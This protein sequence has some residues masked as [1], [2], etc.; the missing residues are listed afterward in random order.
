MGD[1]TCDF[2]FDREA[3]SECFDTLT[4]EL[5]TAILS[6]RNVAGTEWECPHPS[7]DGTY[8][9]FHRDSENTSGDEAQAVAEAL[10]TVESPPPE[11]PNRTQFLGATFDT[12]EFSNVDL[13]VPEE[14][15]LDFLGATFE[16]PVSF[17]DQHLRDPSF[18]GATFQDTVSFKRT[19]L[20]DGCW[21][22]E[23]KFDGVTSFTEASVTGRLRF[24]GAEFT[25]FV[26][27]ERAEIDGP[28]EL[29]NVVCEDAVSMRGANI[30]DTMTIDGGTYHHHVILSEITA[31]DE[32]EIADPTIGG[33]IDI[34]EAEL[35]ERATLD[36]VKILIDDQEAASEAGLNDVDEPDNDGV[37]LATSDCVCE[38]QLYLRDCTIHGSFVGTTMDAPTLAVFGTTVHGELNLTQSTFHRTLGFKDTRISGQ[39]NFFSME[40][41]HGCELVDVTVDGLLEAFNADLEGVVFEDVDF[42][43][44]RFERADLSGGNLAG[45]DLRAVDFTGA[46]MNRAV[47]HDAD[48][49]GA[50]LRG[51]ALGDIRITDNT[52][53][54]NPPVGTVADEGRLPPGLR[55]AIPFLSERMSYCGPDPECPIP[56]DIVDEPGRDWPEPSLDEAKTLYRRIERIAADHSQSRLQSRAF[57]RGQDIRYEQLRQA[58]PFPKLRY[59]FSRLQRAVFVYG[60]SFARVVVV[61]LGTI[62]LFGLLFPLGGWMSTVS[63]SGQLQP[64]TYSRVAQEPVLLWRS[65][66]HSAMMFATGNQYGGLVARN[67]IGEMLT[68]V[69]ALLG[70]TVLALLVFVLGRRAAR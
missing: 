25:E 56:P 21:F 70:P 61:A 41:S 51:A 44:A 69:E 52:K 23:T 65:V 64:L 8:C 54:L 46:T 36:A 13:S 35:H 67:P 42:Q 33:A 5:W 45:A 49:R 53:F 68:T 37:G 27:F 30:E 14:S 15:R 55:E 4:D 19:E 32:V 20:E 6:S 18:S 58:E 29:Q 50:N 48:L 63:V 34:T 22:K 62:L 17:T 24:H 16:G 59:L 66:Y 2:V 31:T 28:F 60:E 57:I 39:L 12:A 40:A 11:E 9:L 43:A 10:A 3:A 47:F 38:K 1:D 7:G 26:G